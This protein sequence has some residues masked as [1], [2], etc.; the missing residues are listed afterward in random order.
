LL[1]L[2]RTSKAYRETLMTR[3]TRSLWKRVLERLMGPL[4]EL[5]PDVSEPQWADLF[6][7]GPE[8]QLCGI[9]STQR[10]DFVSRHRVCVDC[11]NPTFTE[12][13]EIEIPTPDIPR[14]IS[15][16]IPHCIIVDRL[17]LD[18]SHEKITYSEA[19]IPAVLSIYCE[20]LRNGF[21]NDL[22]SRRLRELFRTKQTA[23]IIAILN[24]AYKC[25]DWMK[26]YWLWQENQDRKAR[27]VRYKQVS[28]LFRD[29]GYMQCDI[30]GLVNT[31]EMKED[32]VI[33]DSVWED[34][35]RN[36]EPMVIAAKEARLVRERQIYI[37]R[38]SYL[39][40]RAY[41]EYRKTL[42][43]DQLILCPSLKE[44]YETPNLR[45]LINQPFELDCT[46]HTFSRVVQ[47]TPQIKETSAEN[48]AEGMRMIIVAAIQDIAIANSTSFTVT[49]TS[50]PDGRRLS[51]ATSVYCC[52]L[53]DD[54]LRTPL[55][56]WHDLTSH[57]CEQD[58]RMQQSSIGYGESSCTKL[59]HI[60]QFSTIAAVV[61][62]SIIQML[63]MDVK[64]TVPADLDR[65]GRRFLCLHCPIARMGHGI[66]TRL[67]M[68]WRQCLSHYMGD[69]TKKHEIPHMKLLS[70]EE[71]ISLD[72]M[73]LREV[74]CNT[75]MWS[76]NHC[77][78]HIDNLQVR[79][80]AIR[81]VEQCHRIA[82]PLEDE[83]YFH[84]MPSSRDWPGPVPY[85]ARRV[86]YPPKNSHPYLYMT[87]HPPV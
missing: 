70:F 32:R 81:H 43:P 34:I 46:A 64:S 25:A 14:R 52:L 29:L 35:R 67:A 1:N 26:R 61:A 27:M 62:A 49:P 79:C 37:E 59:E 41:N 36:L 15:E 84:A 66:G 51:L 4:S 76:C 63:G 13:D 69:C 22:A 65:A 73:E 77:D 12:V 87:S 33:S 5:P 3:S 6:F 44:V 80:R 72:K 20:S 16:M 28:R 58:L 19:T 75:R 10:I 85:T 86:L 23:D 7:G 45:A 78:T 54:C 30:F 40:F 47:E 60:F 68:T 74:A 31:D 53:S 82:Q 39:V 50:T 57:Q 8:C 24:H 55:F 38:R 71:S 17:H 11:F 18:N 2:A 83:D 42:Q 48:V 21:V 56:S 9:K